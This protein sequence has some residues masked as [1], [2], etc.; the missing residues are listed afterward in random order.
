MTGECMKKQL[1]LSVTKKVGK[2]LTLLKEKKQFR[3]P[4]TDEPP[5][6][7]QIIE[8]ALKDSGMWILPKKKK[9]NR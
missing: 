3:N 4:L 8:R 5:P 6:Y 7:S 1:K 2:N 9:K